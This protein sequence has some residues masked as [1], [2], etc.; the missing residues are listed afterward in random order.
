MPSW[1]PRGTRR[2]RGSRRRKE[3]RGRT[4]PSLRSARNAAAASA[5]CA[6]ASPNQRDDAGNEPRER[7]ERKQVTEPDDDRRED[8]EEPLDRSVQRPGEARVVDPAVGPVLA[9]RGAL[10][11]QVDGERGLGDLV[12]EEAQLSLDLIDLEL[13]VLELVLHRERLAD[14]RRL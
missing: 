1:K 5:G 3:G 10:F 7:G 13:N 14:G 8:A 6:T 12:V 9:D 2:T 4:P 11:A